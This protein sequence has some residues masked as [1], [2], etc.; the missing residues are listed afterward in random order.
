MFGLTF[1]IYESFLKKMS[2][3][4][5]LVERQK[6]YDDMLKKKLIASKLR[7]N[8]MTNKEKN[9]IRFNCVVSALESI[10]MTFFVGETI[11]LITCQMETFLWNY[12]M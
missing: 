8:G 11:T 12:T 4:C 3:S 6:I 2:D 10:E 9:W 5:F 1:L 7:L